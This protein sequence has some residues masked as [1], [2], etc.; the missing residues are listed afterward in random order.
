MG[1]GWGELLK[2]QD[3]PVKH[4]PVNTPLDKQVTHA[5]VGVVM[6][7]LLGFLIIERSTMVFL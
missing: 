5:V 4:N 6:N 7:L 3:N 2:L 1:G